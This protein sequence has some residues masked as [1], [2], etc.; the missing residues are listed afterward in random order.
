M[1]DVRPLR[2]N[3]ADTLSK[4]NDDE[5][6]CRVE[7]HDF[8]KL[9]PRKQIPKGIKLDRQIDGSWQM[10]RIC[11]CCKTE[12]IT[13][14]QGGS[15]NRQ[16]LRKYIRPPRW[17]TIPRYLDISKADIVAEHFDRSLAPT[18]EY[19]ASQ[20]EELPEAERQ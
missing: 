17:K 19:L 8:P 20:A 9:N 5:L 7:G 2:V 10:T 13:T 12:R 4:I 3:K 18:L 16:V 15:L 14:L 6:T 1:G 11:R